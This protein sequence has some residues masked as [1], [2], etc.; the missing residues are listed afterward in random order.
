[1]AG[2]RSPCKRKKVKKRERQREVRKKEAGPRRRQSDK[3]SPIIRYS[4]YAQALRAYSA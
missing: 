1:M 3:E 4:G 2:G